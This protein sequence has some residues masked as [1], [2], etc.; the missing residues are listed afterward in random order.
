MAYQPPGGYQPRYGAPPQGQGG[1][2]A[3]PQGQA[4]YGAPPPQRAPYGAPA[5]Q[6][7]GA[8]PYG[9]QQ[10]QPYGAPGYGQQPAAGPPPGVD[11]NIYSWFVSVDQDKSGQ[12]TA[13]ELQQAL[14]N[15]NWSHFNAET[16]RLMIG[17][18]DRD[19][20]GTINIQEFSALWNYIQQWKGV[21]ERYDQ[22]KSGAIEANELSTAF[23]QMGYNVSPQFTQMLV[24]KYDIAAR[25]SLKLDDFIQACV[26]LKSLTDSFRQ[27]DT[28]MNGTITISY[29]DFMSLVLL[30]RP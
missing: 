24:A 25:R 21:F 16:C 10:Q 23:V 29:E 30:N 3:P 22:D 18:F 5:G 26:M 17:I 7:Y 9:G 14:T 15:S 12:I 11:P 1:Y 19:Q 8:A 6:P 20:S 28:N 4:G 27:R 13:T 2:G